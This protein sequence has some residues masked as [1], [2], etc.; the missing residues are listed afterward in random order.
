MSPYPKRYGGGGSRVKFI[1]DS[2]NAD[3]GTAYDATN[4]LTTVY[5]EN[6]CIAR[7]LSAAWGTNE[8][9]GNLWVPTRASMDIIARWERIMALSPLPTDTDFD[10]RAHVAALFA[11][12]GQATLSAR[13]TTILTAALGASFVAVEHI[14]YANAN[15]LVPDATY[16]WGAFVPGSSSWSSTSARILVRMT[17]PAGWTEYDFYAAAGLV[18]TLIDPILPVWSTVD[19][20]RPGP[21]NVNVSGGPSAGGFYLDDA[22]NLD[23]EVIDA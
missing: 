4:R 9:L 11:R 3:R 22:N 17:K 7:A 2:L 12:F 21:I 1:L 20:Y 14:S 5:V 16:P 15:I 6:M 19:W 18:V 10:R 8:R 13:I 23:N